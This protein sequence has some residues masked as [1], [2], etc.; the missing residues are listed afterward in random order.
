MT[1]PGDPQSVTTNMFDHK[2]TI[3]KNFR[4]GDLNSFF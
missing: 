1:H 4:D 2:K 3:I